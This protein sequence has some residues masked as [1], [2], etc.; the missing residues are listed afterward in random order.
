V[1]AADRL[2]H[3]RSAGLASYRVKLR[4]IVSA[5]NRLN[6][7]IIDKVEKAWG[8]TIRDGFGQ[9]ENVCL[10]GNFPGQPVKPGCVGKPS[11]DN[12]IV[13]LDP[14]DCPPATARFP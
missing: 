4:E 1:C 8:V 13:L 11:P 12:D 6:P 3:V 9:T 5:V 10:L 2:A 14:M 7:E